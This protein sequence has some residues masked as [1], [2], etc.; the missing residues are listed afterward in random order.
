MTGHQEA[1]VLVIGIIVAGLTLCSMFG[2]FTARARAK[3]GYH[4]ADDDDESLIDIEYGTGR[5][6]RD[7][8]DR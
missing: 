2:M 7:S 4:P 6:D 5:D 3:Y 8:D 1:V